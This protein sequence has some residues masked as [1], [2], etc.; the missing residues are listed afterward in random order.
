[1][2]Q[3]EGQNINVTYGVHTQINS[4]FTQS[5]TAKHLYCGMQ[6]QSITV[7]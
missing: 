6:D 2:W 1:M 7:S 3:H 5:Q 4:H